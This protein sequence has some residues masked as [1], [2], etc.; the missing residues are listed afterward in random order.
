VVDD[1]DLGPG[2]DLVVLYLGDH[3][4]EPDDPA[5]PPA[6]CPPDELARRTGRPVT[7]ARYRP[8]FPAGLLEDVLAAYEEA[9]RHGPVVIVG[10]RL[11]AGLAAGLLVHLRDA[12][13]EQPAAAVLISAMLDLTLQANSVSLNVLADH[14]LE[15]DALRRR[16]T[17]YCGDQALTRPLLSPVYANL[18]GLAPVQL[19][20]AGTDLLL[21]DSLALAA[22]AARSGVRVDLRVWPEAGELVAECLSATADF[23]P[24][25]R[26]AHSLVLGTDRRPAGELTG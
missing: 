19:L 15:L 13:Q 20:T 7:V 26:P 16:V 24:T 18:H 8:S 4:G 23:L 1:L 2:D 6:I 12:G 21:D 9:R 10:E 14:S 5:R 11:G 25:I 3:P 22:R 17:D